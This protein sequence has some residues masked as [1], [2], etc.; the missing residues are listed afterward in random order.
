MGVG[1]GV[2]G[3][4]KLPVGGQGLVLV[5]YLFQGLAFAVVGPDVVGVEFEDLID[6]RQGR[7]RLAQGQV[8]QAA[9][10]QNPR[11]LGVQLPGPGYNP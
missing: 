3:F 10:V 9:V 5:A 8:D 2:G 7:F 6:V 1:V 4:E 11:R